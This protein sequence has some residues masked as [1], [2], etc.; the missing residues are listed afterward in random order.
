MKIT[1][2]S[3]ARPVGVLVGVLLLTVLGAVSVTRLP[4]EFLPRKD[5]PFIGVYVPYPNAVPAQVEK[6]IARPVEEVLATL[7]DVKEMFSRSESDGAFVGVRFEFGRDVDVLRLE[8][9][10]KLDQVRPLLPSDVQNLFIFTFNTNDIPIMVGRISAHGRDLAS[11]YDLLDRH[12]IK[13]LERVDGVG[14]VQVDGVLPADISIYLDIDRVLEHGVDVQA[15]FDRIASAN[16]DLGLGKVHL[17]GNRYRIRAIGEFTS[18]DELENLLVDQRGVRLRD[19]ADV[20]YDEPNPTY[21]RRLNGEPAVAFEIQRASGANIVDV[22]RGVHETLD[23]IREDPALD[24]IDVVLFFDQAEQITGGLDGLLKSGMIGSVL[25]LGVIFVFLR[26]FVTTAVIS[27]AIPFSIV[28]A[29]VFLYLS[30]RSLNVLTMMG[31]MLATGMLVDNAI[32]V[33]ESIH[34][35]QAHSGDTPEA[36]ALTGTRNVARAVIAATL[37]SICVFAP[38][39]LT[40]S[41][42]LAVW[43]GEVGYTII[44]ALSFS[45]LI[46]LTLVPLMMGR[47][48]RHARRAASRAHAGGGERMPR[49]LEA[50]KRAYVKALSW[51]AIR[52]PIGTLGLVAASVVL[53]VVVAK[54]S[55]FSPASDGDRGIKRDALPIEVAF[56]DNV[57]LYG[58]DRYADRLESFLLAKRDSLGVESVYT[59]YTDNY[60]VSWLYFSSGDTSEDE[61][62]ELREYLRGRL[63]TIPGTRYTIGSED[64]DDGA[65]QLS[66]TLFGDD[67][68]YLAE[69]AAEAKRRLETVD[70]LEDVHSD[71]ERGRDEVRVSLRPDESGRFGVTPR[72][73]AEIL[74]LT[75]RGMTIGTYKGPDREVPIG[76][77]LE[78]GSRRSIENLS[79]MVVSRV[80]GTDISLGQIAS[81]EV[82][83]GPSQIYRESRRTAVPVRASYEGESFEEALEEVEA[84]MSSLDMPEGYGWSFGRRFR[85][86]QAESDQMGVNV[87]L[88]L[89]CVYFVMAS[90]FESFVHPLV[91]MLCI[92]FAIIGVIWMCI[93]TGT[94]LNILGMIG[95]VILIGIVVNNGIILIDH[96]NHHRRAGLSRGE[97]ILRGGE[98]RFRP[99]LMTALTTILG[100]VPLAFGSAS[101]GDGYYYPM[102]RAVMAG[103]AASTV[104]TLL[105]LPTFYVIA[106]R[107]T[108]WNRRVW[109]RATG[110]LALPDRGTDRIAL[111]PDA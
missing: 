82:G 86:A 65:K 5:F 62:R 102:A 60:L 71:L 35:R 6:E 57:N 59:F 19:V 39:V 100:L 111:T 68:D 94:P 74:N 64:A 79:A 76:I 11:A 70:G 61:L 66:V 107:I 98:E 58:V 9:K 80:D 105:V 29:C 52:H 36:A 1:E 25:A 48:V 99:I 81:F 46:S 56:D 8:V 17:D 95:I 28:S 27:V 50:L 63:P 15:L 103:L 43:L 33:L 42:E 47:V 37:T 83:R 77:V 22:S 3:L 14:R 67:T 109:W 12:V 44:V 32:V 106:E 23:A 24:G 31:L 104:L 51:T 75:F 30:D 54:V 26:R 93:L 92:P 13:P 96:I 45:L 40:P 72:T 89:A 20:V 53:T 90:L 97:A 21:R 4:L 55:G 7:G 38:V 85:E 78:P 84:L 91:I 18:V 101:I 87:L 73:M 88:A 110:R 2:L 69:L 16:L 10:E 108:L 34:R 41:S 49:A